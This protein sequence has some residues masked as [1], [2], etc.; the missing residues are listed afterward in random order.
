MKL[1]Y[2]TICINPN[3]PTRQQGFLYQTKPIYN[4]HDD[5]HARIVAF[6]NDSTIVYLISC[7]NL[8]FPVTIQNS[9]EHIYNRKRIRKYM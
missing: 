2:S 6:E 4:F 9:L 3:R 1:A 5:L 8:G 7:D